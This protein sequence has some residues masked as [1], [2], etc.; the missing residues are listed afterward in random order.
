MRVKRNKRL[1][2]NDVQGGVGYYIGCES[3]Q[4]VISGIDIYGALTIPER[5]Q[6]IAIDAGR[7]V[8]SNSHQYGLVLPD[9]S[10]FTANK[11]IATT[12]FLETITGYGATKV[13]TLKNINGVF[14]W[15]DD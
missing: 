9:T 10:L 4:L 14:T 5:I 13:Q 11:I 2:F 12:D 15:I 1:Y 3:N 7:F 6:K 8:K